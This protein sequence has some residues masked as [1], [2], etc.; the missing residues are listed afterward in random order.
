MFDKY[1]QDIGLSE[2]E[3]TIYIALLSFDKVSI[4]ELSKK[5]EV[6]RPTTYVILDSLAK[7][8]LVSEISVEKKTYYMAEPP[9]KLGLFVERQ[10][11]LLEGSRKSLEII[12]PKLKD[13]V[14]GVD[15]SL[16]KWHLCERCG[17]KITPQQSSQLS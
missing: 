12:I 15:Y 13:L 8:G 7:K 11:H 16:K 6:K 17:A 5:A 3:A 4:A 9:E 10:I 14:K 1:L 2:K